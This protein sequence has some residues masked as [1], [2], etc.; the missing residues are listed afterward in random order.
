[1]ACLHRFDVLT[2]LN[3]V[4]QILASLRCRCVCVCVNNKTVLASEGKRPQVFSKTDEMLPTI[5][6]LTCCVWVNHLTKDHLHNYHVHI[7]VSTQSN[8]M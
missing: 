5:C 2:R 3:D 4:A 8:Q 7:Q 6:S 1:M